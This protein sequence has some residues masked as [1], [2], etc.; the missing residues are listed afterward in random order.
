MVGP[1]PRSTHVGWQR[2]PESRERPGRRHPSGLCGCAQVRQVGEGGVTLRC[3]CGGGGAKRRGLR[4]ER[5]RCG[6]KPPS[7]D[8]QTRKFTRRLLEGISLGLRV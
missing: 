3:V 6:R 4:R 8:G 5:G 2:Q 7:S 1:R